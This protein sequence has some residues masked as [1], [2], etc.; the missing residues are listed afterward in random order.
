MRHEVARE[1]QAAP[2]RTASTRGVAGEPQPRGEADRHGQRVQ[3]V[4]RAEEEQ[5]AVDDSLSDKPNLANETEP[6]NRTKIAGDGEKTEDP[7]PE[8]RAGLCPLKAETQA[9]GSPDS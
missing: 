8:A 7:K 2:G 4:A 1:M 3:Q 6:A 9:L 5:V